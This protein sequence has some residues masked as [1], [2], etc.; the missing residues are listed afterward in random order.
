MNKKLGAACMAAGFLLACLGCSKRSTESGSSDAGASMSEKRTFDVLDARG[1]KV[2]RI[3]DE[4][5]PLLSTALPPR[6]RSRSAI[7]S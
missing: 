1:R 4:P 5:G 2:L 7:R 6:A 3:K